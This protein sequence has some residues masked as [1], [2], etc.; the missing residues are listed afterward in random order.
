MTAPSGCLS[1]VSWLVVIPSVKLG[2]RNITDWSMV[3]GSVSIHGPQTSSITW[4]LLRNA[5]SGARPLN[6]SLGLEFAIGL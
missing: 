5:Y 6:H 2:W 4:E 3:E 1:V